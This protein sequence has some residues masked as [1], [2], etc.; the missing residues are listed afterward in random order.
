ML[1]RSIDM[2]EKFSK[3]KLSPMLRETP[4]LAE[5]VHDM[6]IAAGGGMEHTRPVL[7]EAA[8]AYMGECRI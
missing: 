8:A 7:R 1:F 3:E 6:R 4:V 5:R 2:A